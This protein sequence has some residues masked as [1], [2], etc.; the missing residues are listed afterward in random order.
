LTDEGK[1]AFKQIPDPEQFMKRAHEIYYAWKKTQPDSDM[2]VDSP[3][4][5]PKP[6][7]YVFVTNV[8]LSSVS[9]GGRDQADALI[10]KHYKNL[11]LKGHAVWD[12]NQ[13]DAF[14]ARH[15]DSGDDSPP[16]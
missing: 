14:L 10:L 13:L 8:D 15:S 9:G 2:F 3:N 5:D 1:A 7:Y 6:E 4:R 16:S 12:A 11:P